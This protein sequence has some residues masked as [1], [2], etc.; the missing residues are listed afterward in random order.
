MSEARNYV[1]ELLKL[2]AEERSAAAEA[3]LVSLEGEAADPEAGSAWAEEIGR[4]VAESAPGIPAD[5]VFAEG[6]ARL[7][8]N[9]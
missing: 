3:L 8:S 7:K 4:R 1:D 9:T 6:R 5:Q 2:P